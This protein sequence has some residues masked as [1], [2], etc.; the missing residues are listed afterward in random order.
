LICFALTI[1]AKPE[2]HEAN[3]TKGVAVTL[4]RRSDPLAAQLEGSAYSG[5]RGSIAP[6][7]FVASGGST[8]LCEGSASSVLLLLLLL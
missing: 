5:G 4:G 3:P 1:A 8:C 6:E 2:V 7:C